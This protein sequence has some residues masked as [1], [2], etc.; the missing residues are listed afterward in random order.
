MPLTLINSRYKIVRSLGRGGFGETS[1]VEDTQL[2]SGR[3]CVLKQLIPIEENLQVYGLVQERF[4]REAAILEELGEASDQIPRLYAYFA[5]NHRFYLVQEYVEGETL[6]DRFGREGCLSEALVRELLVG[7]LPVLSYVHGRR[8]IH[9]DIKPDNIMVRNR[10]QKPVLIDFGA[11]RETMGTL[12]NSQGKSTQSIVIGT[13]GFMP[14]EQAAGRPVFSSDLYSLGLTC[15]YLLTGR[16]PETLPVDPQTGEIVW[17]QFAP[18]VT[19]GF[20]DLLERAVRSQSQARFQTAQ[21]MLDALMGAP[22]GSSPVAGPTKI[23][24]LPQPV[25]TQVVAPQGVVRPIALAK[26][27][28]SDWA[29][30]LMMGGLIGGFVL[31]GLVIMRSPQGAVSP[32]VA[33][34]PVGISPVASQPANSPS[35]QPAETKPA[36]ASSTVIVQTSDSGRSPNSAPRSSSK[37]ST[38]VER[39]DA[40]DFVRGYYA[41]I[42]NRNYSKSWQALSSGFQN[43]SQGYS[44]YTD[45]WDSV[46]RVQTNAVTVSRQDGDRAEVDANLRYVMKDGGTDVDSSRFYL[47]WN[48]D[49]QSWEMVDK[50][51]S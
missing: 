3:Y 28:L 7:I 24:L 43:Q 12:V 42:N 51:R 22:L 49:R 48:G 32:V 35:S 9:R 23:S 16:S 19:P 18:Q 15:V 37:S 13:P 17:R 40:G 5:E 6:A 27:G 41:E 31:A 4:Q 2:P 1:L 47:E 14:S 26:E 36:P 8:M 45:W 33:V 11:V 21:Q 44:S 30:M 10:D 25:M 38:S 20:G 39:S 29:K 46:A 50:V 34:P